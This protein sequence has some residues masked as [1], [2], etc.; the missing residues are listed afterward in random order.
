EAILRW[1]HQRAEALARRGSVAPPILL[2]GDD[3]EKFGMWPQTYTPMWEEDGG[4]IN[5]FFAALEANAGWLETITVGEY[6]PRFPAAGRIYLP[7][8]SY[9]EMTEWALPAEAA[10]QIKPIKQVLEKSQPEALRFLRGGFWRNFM[11]KYP[12]V[13]TLHKKALAVSRLVHA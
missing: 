6:A 11:V 4:F 9:D 5:R 13:N 12:E 8:S 2:M 7:T 1:L 10:A 3:G